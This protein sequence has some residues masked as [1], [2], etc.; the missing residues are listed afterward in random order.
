MTRVHDLL[1]ERWLL[2]S[3]LSFAVVCFLDPWKYTRKEAGYQ[4]FLSRVLESCYGTLVESDMSSCARYPIYLLV[5]S[6]QSVWC[7]SFRALSCRSHTLQCALWRMYLISGGTKTE[8]TTVISPSTEGHVIR[9]F[10]K[11]IGLRC[12]I[13]PAPVLSLNHFG[14]ITNIKCFWN[15]WC[16]A[17]GW[18]IPVTKTKTHFGILL[19]CSLTANKF[20]YKKDL[21]YVSYRE[22]F[23][24]CSGSMARRNKSKMYISLCPFTTQRVPHM[25]RCDGSDI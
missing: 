14:G 23:G 8:F 17:I 12:R 16:P 10:Y 11:S 21:L 5:F 9:G 6:E 24:T 25:S 2:L 3:L 4:K 7:D 19:C 18:Y 22:Q 1:F 20:Y 13:E 15:R